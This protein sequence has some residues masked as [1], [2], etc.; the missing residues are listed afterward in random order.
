MTIRLFCKPKNL[1]DILGTFLAC[2]LGIVFFATAIKVLTDIHSGNININ[3]DVFAYGLVML[4]FSMSYVMFYMGFYLMKINI[5][6]FGWKD[7][8]E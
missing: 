7:C 8:N 6:P 1:G 5:F 4:L 2:G 3:M